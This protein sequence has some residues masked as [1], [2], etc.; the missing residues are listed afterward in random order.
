MKSVSTTVDVKIA[1]AIKIYTQLRGNRGLSKSQ[2]AQAVHLSFASVSNMCTSLEEKKL[3]HVINNTQSTGGRKAAQI[4]LNADAAHTVVIDMHHTQHIYLA[5]VNLENIIIDSNRFEVQACDSLDVILENI[6]KSYSELTHNKE[7]NILGISVGISAV[8]NPETRSLLQ[9][10]NP[11]FDKVNLHNHL[12][13]IFP[14]KKILVEN[15][16]NLAA[17]SQTGFGESDKK[18]LLFIFFTQGIGLGIMINGNLYRGTNGFAGELG[19]LK[20]YRW[21]KIV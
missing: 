18:N 2:L 14:D 3:L 12:A 17:L 4:I 19:H 20:S 10:T 21:N 1:N 11:V 7:Y 9:S 6:R 15:D 16:A 5:I 13:E 8:F